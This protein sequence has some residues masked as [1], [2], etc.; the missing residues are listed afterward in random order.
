MCSM[1]R[2]W[3]IFALSLFLASILTAVYPPPVSAKSYSI[4]QDEF[5]IWIKTDKSID[6]VEYLTYSFTGDFSWA[7]MWIPTVISRQGYDY[8][9]YIKNFT[10]ESTDQSPVRLESAGDRGNSFYAQWKYTAQDEKKTFKINYTV[11][12]AVIKHPQVAELYRQFIGPEW[13]VDHQ[14]VTIVIHLP[15]P[16]T[17]TNQILVYGHGPLSGQSEILD[18][19]TVRFTIDRI[20]K[21]QF[22]EVRVVFP[23]TLVNGPIDGTK[24]KQEI[25]D[26]EA[27][28]VQQPIAAAEKAQRR[29]QQLSP[30]ILGLIGLF[31]LL[32][33]GWVIWWYRFWQQYGQE[34]PTPNPPKYLRDLPSELNPAEVE[35]LLKQGGPPSIN[36]FTATLF[37]LARRGYLR[38]EDQIEQKTG[39]LTTH[40]IHHTTLALT[41]PPH[42]STNQALKTYE[43]NLLDLIFSRIGKSPL[44]IL[45]NILHPQ[46]AKTNRTDNHVT[47]D[48]VKYWLKNHPREFQSWFSQ[49]QDEVQN[50]L[51]KLG[52]IEGQSL[53][54]FKKAWIVTVITGLLSPLIFLLGA[55][56]NP[57]LK[58]WKKNWV[59]TAQR[60]KAFRRFLDDF[61]KFERLPP[62]SYKLWESYLV[63]GILFGNAEKI[64]KML[65]VIL[66]NPQA[67][68][69]TWYA[70]SSIQGTD[71]THT[72]QSISRFSN[73]LN[74][75][76]S[77]L[78]TASTSAAHYSSGSGGGFS[79]GGGGGSG[80]GGG[81]AG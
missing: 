30:L 1:A 36:A 74:V 79:G 58:R 38:I 13:E 4:P 52:V 31:I 11:E 53:D 61:A 62:E 80:G 44:G 41:Q 20:A 3:R 16:V 23:A 43:R 21:G 54:A 2:H 60:W 48:E 7:E 17:N 63:F 65:P 22:A 8:A 33:V 18:P 47:F 25:Q 68:T 72:I 28:Y 51:E 71:S 35:S 45:E 66:T 42:Q 56:L 50:E 39:L 32:P 37:D 55:I 29:Q 46:T 40:Q 6:V 26:E 59:I 24:S 10:V 12:N 9:T 5:E 69:A 49:W 34:H 77:E 78:Q 19:V 81:G 75:L 67:Q 64:L 70:V 27:Q 14:N 15:Q 76:T 73:S 57:H